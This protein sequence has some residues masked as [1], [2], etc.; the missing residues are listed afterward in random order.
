M[1]LGIIASIIGIGAVAGLASGILGIGGGIL[2]VPALI[3]VLGYG[4]H[5]AQG[6]TLALLCLPVGIV[7]ALRY[8]QQGFVEW[9]VAGILFCGFLVGAY[10]GA[11]IA[12]NI[13]PKVLRQVF[14]ATLVVAGVRMLWSR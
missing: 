14:G 9:R 4:Q 12:L 11:G 6:T 3:Y 1:T 13:S 2:L 10:L 5:Q 7:A 8:H